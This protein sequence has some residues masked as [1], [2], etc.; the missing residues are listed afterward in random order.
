MID[1]HYLFQHDKAFAESLGE[2]KR[3]QRAVEAE[4]RKKT[5]ETRR[6]SGKL[7][8][9]RP[10]TPDHGKL[11]EEI[12]ARQAELQAEL[13]LS[14]KRF[15]RLEG[16]A[17]EATYDEVVD[18]VARFAEQHDVDAVYR[19]EAGGDPPKA[20]A[21]VATGRTTRAGEAYSTSVLRKVARQ[22]I[23]RRDEWDITHEIL[24]MLDRERAEPEGEKGP[25][26][27]AAL[28]R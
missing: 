26:G 23:Y 18:A 14:K 9:L 2:V 12:A 6:L 22:V 7:A 15:L 11:E 13:A 16:G 20:R 3:Q 21:D 25:D 8:R 19:K 4:F 1:M 5:A 10:G 27:P 17:Y 28:N 24:E